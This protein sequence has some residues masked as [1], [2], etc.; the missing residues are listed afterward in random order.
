MALFKKRRIPSPD[1]SRMSLGE[2]LEELRGCVARSLIALVLACLAF[3]WPAKYL[4]QIIA[5]P[6][7]LVLRA[8]GQPDSFLATSPVENIVV[9]IKVVL[10]FG[11]I[12]AAPYILYQIWT[13]VA[14]GLYQHERKW[15]HRLIPT[16]VGLFL[17]GAIFMYLFVLLISLN[18]LVGFSGWLSLPQPEPNA[19]ERMVLHIPQVQAPSTAPGSRDSPAVPLLAQDP[20]EPQVGEIWVNVHD[21]KLKVRSP[22][23]TYSLQLVRDDQHAL[24]TTHFRIGDYLTFVLVM[25]IAFGFAFQMPLVVVFLARA[26]IVPVATFR[27]YRKLVILVIV[28]TAGLLAPPDFMSHALLSG[29]MIALFELGLWLAARKRPPQPAGAK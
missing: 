25:M 5:R 22:D 11:M 29:P 1:D 10:I 14:A 19:L 6:V 26:G 2:H 21:R 24:V 9:Y 20:P 17:A 4:L 18:F 16:S 12:V 15:V 3:I 7:V 28:F 27:K 8:H 13:F 23:N